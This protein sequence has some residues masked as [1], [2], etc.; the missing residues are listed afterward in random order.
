MF[1]ARET[2]ILLIGFVLIF[3]LRVLIVAFVWAKVRGTFD[4]VANIVTLALTF[5]WLGLV[6]RAVLRKWATRKST[7]IKPDSGE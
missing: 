6:T 4:I 3:V 7:P 2:R 5:I 1:S